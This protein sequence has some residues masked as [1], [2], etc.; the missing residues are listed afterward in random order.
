MKANFGLMPPLE[1]AVP[2]KRARYAAYTRRAAA[3]LETCL[4]SI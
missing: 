3:A 1:P 4:G 2:S